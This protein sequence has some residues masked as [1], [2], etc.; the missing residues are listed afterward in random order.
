[1]MALTVRDWAMP[2]DKDVEVKPVRV[3]ADGE[4]AGEVAEVT[5]KVC[6][7]FAAL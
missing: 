2:T 1:M 4:M 3:E 7:A 6:V 5:V